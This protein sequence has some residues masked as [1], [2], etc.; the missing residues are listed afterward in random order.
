MSLKRF[1][2]KLKPYPEPFTEYFVYYVGA[3]PSIRT[4][5]KQR[6]RMI[7]GAV[8]VK[9]SSLGFEMRRRCYSQI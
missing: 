6:L 9:E 2:V 3:C 7:F 5:P 1:L 8:V 4:A